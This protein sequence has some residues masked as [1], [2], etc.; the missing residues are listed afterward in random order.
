VEEGRGSSSSSS[1]QVA[2][3]GESMSAGKGGM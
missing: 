2:A 1:L 3:V